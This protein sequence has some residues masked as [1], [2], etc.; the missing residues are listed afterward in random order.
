M[1]ELYERMLEQQKEMIDRLE[2]LIR[3]K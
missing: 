3:E 2:K 1:V